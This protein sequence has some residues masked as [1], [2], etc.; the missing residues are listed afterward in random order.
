[1]FK[2]ETY[3][4]FFYC[5]SFLVKQVVIVFNLRNFFKILLNNNNNNLNSNIHY[6]SFYSDFASNNFDSCSFR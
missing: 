4:L 6:N 3:N 5:K 2:C 1:M